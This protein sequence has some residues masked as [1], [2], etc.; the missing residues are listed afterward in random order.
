[1][2]SPQDS[3]GTSSTI[4]ALLQETRRFPPSAEFTAN[5][6]VRDPS[7][8]QR[9]HDD[10][11]GFWAEAANRLDWFQRWDKVLEWDAPWAKWFVG[12]K[13]NASYNAV[14][15]HNK[16][17]RRNKAAIIWEGEPG[18]SRVLTY[19]DMYREVNEFAAVLLDLGVTKGDRVAFYMPMIPELAIGLLACARIG[20]PHTV[21][22]GG[23]SAEALRDRAIDC[24]AKVIVTADG[25]WRRGNV[26]ALKDIADAA[27]AEA[28]TV[29]KML[30]VRRLAAGVRDVQMMDG[31]DVWYH[32][33]VARVLRRIVE[34]E[35]L[36]SEHPLYI[37]YTSG[38]TGKPKGQ[39]HTT[40]G[41]L[42]GTSLTHEWIFD[43]KEDD[44]YWCTADIGWVTGHSYIVY[45]PLTNG[46]TC[47]MYEGAPDYPDKDR[48]W[49][50]IEKYRATI[51]Y[52]A[53]TSIRTFM[54][55]GDQY[56]AAH[57][58]SSLR[59]LGTVGEPINPEAWIWYNTHIGH[60]NC[61]I[62]DTWWQTETGMIM[63]TPLPG[64]TATKPGSA[65]M[66]FPG[67]EA[68][69]LDENGNSVP[70]NTGGNLVI[71]RPWP[72]MSRRIWGDPDRYVRTYWEKYPGYYLTG[73]GARRDEDG[74][75]WLLGRVDDVLNVSG[76]RIGTMEVES[77]LVSHPAVAEAAVIGASDPITGQAIVAFVTPRSGNTPNDALT[78]ELREHVAHAIGALARPKK[79]YFTSELPKTRSAKIMR[80]LLR[81]IAEGRVL[82]DTTT[83]LDPNIV[84]QIK[85]QYESTEG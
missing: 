71:K 4:D 80:R 41:Y 23:F 21:I 58:L 70:A 46:A 66:P 84:A 45:G 26:I 40:G 28:P 25:G 54:R 62:V 33:A 48:F 55:W 8:Y 39:M 12:G 74:Y 15:R 34:P 7:V 52:T 59:L 35:A 18:D 85:D 50:I 14:D 57:D 36:D 42:V 1:M 30:V 43:L 61:P 31:R 47:V 67:V 63:I 22:F 64:I 6:N 75:F 3:S 83:L 38:T 20:A 37:M 72:A 16:T 44:V 53:P 77:A 65:T 32:D 69:I 49:A 9:A 10:P 73:D 13:L 56:P 79:I 81:D 29:E 78:A 19:A 24:Q 27:A 82:G 17:W 68:D 11:E 76:H 60:E 5:A 2:A 51:L